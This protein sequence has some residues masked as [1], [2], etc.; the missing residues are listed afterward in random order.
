MQKIKLIVCYQKNGGIGLGVNLLYSSKELPG[1]MKRFMA[2]RKDCVIIVGRVTW[3]TLRK[4]PLPD[5]VNVV[6]SGRNEFEHDETADKICSDLLSAVIWAQK[7]H[8]Q[9][10][11]AII[12]GEGIYN[13]ALKYDLVDIIHA[14]EVDDQRPADKFFL[15]PDIFSHITWEEE[16]TPGEG[17]TKFRFRNYEKVQQSVSN[18]RGIEAE[19]NGY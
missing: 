8:P 19:E 15:K 17:G 16:Q 13:E 6:I 12:G 1:D 9:K 5:C 4:H 11:I 10:D 14:T 2:L 3:E 7:M 18:F